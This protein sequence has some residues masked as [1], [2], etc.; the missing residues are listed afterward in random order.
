MRLWSL[1]SSLLDTKGLV[2]LWREALLAQKV[3]Q[4]KTMG[5]R[6]HPQL[7]RFRQCGKPMAA[8]TTYLWAVHDEATARGYAFDSS[9]IAG[10]RQALH[11]AVSRGLLAYEWSHFKEK[12]QLRDPK[13]FRACRRRQI[14]AHPIFKVVAGGIEDWERVAER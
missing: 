9:K 12:V 11:L 6:H 4:G 3:L 5:Y 8:I 7:Q 14:V 10:H 2:A 1:H 13:H